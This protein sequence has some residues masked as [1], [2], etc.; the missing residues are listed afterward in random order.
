MTFKDYVLDWFHNIV[1][2]HETDEEW[3]EDLFTQ[4]GYNKTE[5]LDDDETYDFLMAMD[6][7]AEIYGSIFGVKPKVKCLDDLPDAESFITTMFKEAMHDLEIEYDFVDELVRDMV[8]HCSGYD[9]PVGFFGDLA[10]G[11]CY[12]GLVGMFVCHSACKKFYID[13]IDEMEDYIEYELGYEMQNPHKL[14]H[15]TLVCWVCYEDIAYRLANELWNGN[16]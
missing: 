1:D 11:G 7:E 3:L 5:H 12:S 14:P 6:D 13:H 10:H 9:N 8:E 15:Y 16:F 2:E 4:L